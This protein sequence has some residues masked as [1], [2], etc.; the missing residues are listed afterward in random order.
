MILVRLRDGRVTMNLHWDGY[1]EHHQSA[2]H[3]LTIPELTEGFHD[4]GFLSQNGRLGQKWCNDVYPSSDEHRH[5]YRQCNS[6]GLTWITAI[7][8]SIIVD[9]YVV[10]IGQLGLSVHPWRT[11]GRTLASAQLAREE[12][13]RPRHW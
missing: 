10:A 6:G 1:G 3:R 12:D 5:Y 11:P 13:Y 2:G 7:Q 4:Y 8:R 9:D